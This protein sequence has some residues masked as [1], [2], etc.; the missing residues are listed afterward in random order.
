MSDPARHRAVGVDSEISATSAEHFLHR[1]AEDVLASL[2]DGLI[3]LDAGGHVAFM[4]PAAE[5]LTAVS[6]KH[7]SGRTALQVFAGHPWLAE[8][9]ATFLRD[10]GRRVTDDGELATPLG[11]R[12]PV[13]LTIAPVIDR[14]GVS[15]GSLMRLHDSVAAGGLTETGKVGSMVGELAAVAAGLAHEIKNP[16]GGIK[17]AAQLLAD[18]LSQDPEGLRFT[19]LIT[20][21]V[22]RVAALLEQLLELT[23][24]PRLRLGAV[25]IHRLLQEVLALEHASAG[26]TLAVR[27]NFDPSLPDVWADEARI[28][29][30]FLNL[31]KNAL[32]AMDHTGTLTITTRMETDFRVRT[33]GRDRRSR[34]YLSV[35]VE[36]S[37]PGIDPED[38]ARIFTPFF[39]TKNKGTGLGLAV[40][41]RLVTQHD[42]LLRVESEP[43]R[44]TRFRVS[45]PLA[46][47]GESS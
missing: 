39:T 5:D 34:Q 30:V 45:L 11:Q 47:P 8:R 16:L 37:G 4:S 27:L 46:M 44:W 18:T 2:G 28:R 43:G 6:A 12:T 36:D 21:E 31:V 9:I 29:Q 25:N 10:A 23:R 41:H 15:V 40:S 42:G 13:R 1:Y 17:G 32:E 20:R 26:E 7:A 22:D 38:R 19:S 3:I 24:P 14:N 33:A 35:D